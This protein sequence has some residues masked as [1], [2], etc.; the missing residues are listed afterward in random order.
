M[1]SSLKAVAS[2]STRTSADSAKNPP[3]PVYRSPQILILPHYPPICSVLVTVY[4][5][6]STACV[7]TA[8]LEQTAVRVWLIVLTIARAKVLA[9]TE[10]ASVTRDISGKI[11]RR[12]R[13][14]LPVPL[15]LRMTTLRYPLQAHQSLSAVL[16]TAPATASARIVCVTASQTGLVMPVISSRLEMIWP[17]ELLSRSRFLR[18]CRKLSLL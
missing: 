4:V 13:R 18:T 10:Y 11:A 1:D 8:F 9:L 17:D 3:V 6:R 12:N 7:M 15:L 5:I 16:W 14:W 2:V